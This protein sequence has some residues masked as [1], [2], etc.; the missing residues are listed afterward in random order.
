MR[1]AAAIAGVSLDTIK[2]RRAKGEFAAT[3]KDETGTWRIPSASLVSVAEAEGWT[4]TLPDASPSA[5]PRAGEGQTEE[6]APPEHDASP[7]A[8]LVQQMELLERAHDA[9]VAN[10]TAELDRVKAEAEAEKRRN[11][12]LTTDIEH[13]RTERHRAE[14]DG[15]KAAGERD[16]LTERVLDL[17]DQRQQLSTE[18]AEA[19]ETASER[20]ESLQTE[21][22]DLT[23][24]RD[25]ALASLGWW[26]RRKYN[27]A[28]PT[29]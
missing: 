28:K 12:Q 5:S 13:E 16:A 23:D 4:L 8:A 17:T 10:L 21:I 15:A 14:V 24:D 27:R 6:T 22:L 9:E 7:S 18:L 20:A 3:V 1:E 26:S 11:D 25:N 2:R 19:R 29:P